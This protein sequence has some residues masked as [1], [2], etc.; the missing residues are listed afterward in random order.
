V[1]IVPFAQYVNVG[2][3]Q[4]NQ[5]WLDTNGQTGDDLCVGSRTGGLNQVVDAGGTQIPVIPGASCGEA[6]QPLTNDYRAL[7]TT[8]ANFNASGWTYAPAG[9]MWGWRTLE[10]S[11]PFTEAQSSVNGQKVLVLMTD[12][13]NT[14]S[15]NGQTHE[16]KSRANAD[17]TTTE[18]CNRVKGSDITVYTI[19]Y[20][21]T[22]AAT[23][24]LL[25]NCA[26][27]PENYFDAHNA[28]DLDDAFT[29]ISATLH[30]LR[31]T[32]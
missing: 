6:I 25:E 24:N 29:N 12:G 14:R 19:A 18:M 3:D 20:E 4:S 2:A 13:A 11:A 5:G 31:I 32:S 8:I 26:S 17:N 21:I 27:S 22:D 28:G 23:R 15:A 7:K 10:P 9:L 16:G 30:E 1:S